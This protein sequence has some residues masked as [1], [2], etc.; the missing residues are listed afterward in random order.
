MLHRICVKGVLIQSPIKVV[1]AFDY[2]VVLTES[3]ITDSNAHI[4]YIGVIYI[5]SL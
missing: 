4:L 2:S 1:W 3:F 5:M